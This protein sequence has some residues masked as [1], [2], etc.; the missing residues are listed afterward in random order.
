MKI[1][2]EDKEVTKLFSSFTKYLASCESEE[3]LREM[4]SLRVLPFIGI[5]DSSVTHIRHEYS[6]LKGRIDSLYGC[7]ILE[8][9]APGEIPQHNSN[10]KFKTIQDCTSSN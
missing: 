9:K 5:P 10:K 3:E 4:F 2:L 1:R 7:A 6:V 8:F